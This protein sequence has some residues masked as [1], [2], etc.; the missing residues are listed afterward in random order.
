MIGCV[1]TG[2]GEFGPGLSLAVE[3]I[4]GKQEK[5]E[6]VAFREDQSL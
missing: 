3:M 4:A 6:V 2:H 5:F 1:I